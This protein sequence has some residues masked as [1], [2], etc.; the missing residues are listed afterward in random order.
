MILELAIA[1]NA[2]CNISGDQDLLM[3]NPFNDIPI[4]TAAEFLEFFLP[5]LLRHERTC[6]GG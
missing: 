2:S 3:L 4:V 6:L 5:I 1:S